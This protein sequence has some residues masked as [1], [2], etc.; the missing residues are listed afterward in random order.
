LYVAESPAVTVA[1][2]EPPGA[3]PRF[4]A[5]FP[6]DS[7]TPASPTVW[8]PTLSVTIKVALGE[9]V[10]LGANVTLMVQVPPTGTRVVVQVFVGAKVNSVLLA[11]VTVSAETVRPA[12]VLLVK[13]TDKGEL[14]VLI[15]CSGK[16]R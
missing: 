1:A 10:E 13:I 12:P 9:P 6:E 16:L 4:N 7:T 15:A 11:P 2:V 3:G 14:T 8:V 5:S